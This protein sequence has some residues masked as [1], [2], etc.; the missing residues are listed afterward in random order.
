MIPILTGVRELASNYDAVL[1]DI[2]GVVHN[3]REAYPEAHHAL[4]AYRKSGGTVVLIT[5]APRPWT[6][7]APQLENYGVPDHAWDAI[8][9]SGD[10]TRHLIEADIARPMFHLGPPRDKPV[11]AGLDVN[12]VGEDDAQVVVNTGL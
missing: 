5:N 1:C 2:W 3:G 7:I 8:V 9:T 4:S 12:L 6:E 10:V 11:F